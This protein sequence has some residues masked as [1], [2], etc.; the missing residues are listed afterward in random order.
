[1]ISWKPVD[2]YATGSRIEVII[3]QQ[4]SWTLSRFACTQN[5]INN[6][7]W[8]NDG[9]SGTISDPFMNCLSLAATCT[10]SFFTTIRERTYCTDYS[11]AVASSTGALIKKMNL[12]STTDIIV[13]YVNAA[14]ATEIL[15]TNTTTTASTW[16]VVARIDL[17]K[18]YPINSSPG[19]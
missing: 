4:H 2:P 6:L 10:A 8:Y 17:T 5:T 19:K 9:G 7:A 3:Y 13:G 1:M 18:N 15:K 11:S 12:S 16:R 14:W